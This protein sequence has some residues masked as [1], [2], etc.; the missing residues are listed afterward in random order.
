MTTQTTMTYTAVFVEDG[1]G[2]AAWIEEIPGA[3]SQG[4]TFDEASEDTGTM[5]RAGESEKRSEQASRPAKP[6]WYTA[7]LPSGT[8][9][10]L[11]VAEFRLV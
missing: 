9:D 6:V 5:T 10:A 4:N 2:W 1:D 3:N 11:L 8:E 7:G